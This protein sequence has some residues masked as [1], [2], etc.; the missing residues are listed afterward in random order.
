MHS[1]YVTKTNRLGEYETHLVNEKVLLE[2]ILDPKKRKMLQLL[3]SKEFTTRQLVDEGF[4]IGIASKFV[5][6]ML[7]HGIV[8]RTRYEIKQDG[9]KT[10]YYKSNIDNLTLTL[11]AKQYNF[12]YDAIHLQ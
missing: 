5:Y 12:N 8:F 11:S 9:K 4:S 2:A 6:N 10:G 7:K 3:M 1:K